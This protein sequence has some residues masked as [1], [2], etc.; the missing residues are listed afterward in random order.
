MPPGCLSAELSVGI[1]DEF[2]NLQIAISPVWLYVPPAHETT[3]EKL[4]ASIVP[5][6]STNVSPFS[7]AGRT[8]LRLDVE[9]RLETGV[10]GSLTA[11]YLMASKGQVDMVELARLAGSNGPQTVTR[12]GFDVHGMEI[13]IMHDIG[14]KAIEHRGMFKNAGA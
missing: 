8:P 4:V 14:A 13:R 12:E 11:W 2:D 1:R 5:D 9:P 10:N 6:S 7:S 3:A